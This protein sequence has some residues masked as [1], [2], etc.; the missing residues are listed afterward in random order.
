MKNLLSRFAFLAILI[1]GTFFLI[2]CEQEAV[3]VTSS[4]DDTVTTGNTEENGGDEMSIESDIVEFDTGDLVEGVDYD[5]KDDQAIFNAAFETLDVSKCDAIQNT[6]SKENCVTTIVM[7]VAKIS[8]D[9]TVCDP[10]L[11]ETL[12]T[13]CLNDLGSEIPSPAD[14]ADVEE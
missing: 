4:T 9:P 7:K 8:E 14:S 3:D 1:V 12:K 13:K 6:I 11:D 10:L 2:G 5:P